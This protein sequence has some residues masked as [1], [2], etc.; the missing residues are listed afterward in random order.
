MAETAATDPLFTGGG[1]LAA[2][3][4]HNDWAAT[5]VGPPSTWSPGLRTAVDI[6]LSSRFSMWLG[7]GPELA[8]FY[9][10]AYQRDT[11]QAKHPWALGRPAR[12]VWA[13]IWEEIGPRIESVLH[14]GDAT[15]DE[16]LR[17]VL[18]RRGYPEE[19]YHTFSYSPLRDPAGEIAGMLCVVTENTERVLAGRR[20]AT[21]RDLGAAV[22]AE[23]SVHGVAG[24][25]ATAL[26]GNPHDV[27]FALLILEDDAGTPTL[28]EAVGVRAEHPVAD[29]SAWP[30][31]DS[32]TG[33]AALTDDLGDRFPN[34]PSGTDERPVRQAAVVAFGASPAT[35][36]GVLVVGLNPLRPWDDA[37]RVFVELAANQVAAALVAVHAYEAQARR[38]DELAAL[39]RAKTAFFANTSHEFRT[40]LT[41]M[42]G[43][44]DELCGAQAIAADPNLLR[45]VE[46]IRRNG[47]RL[48]KLVDNLLEFARI[49]A[50]RVEARFEP[51]DLAAVTAGLAGM[52]DSATERAGLDLVL[53][54]PPLPG[55][56]WVDPTMWEKVVLN[57]LSNAVK[58][59][60]AGTI[61]VTL[62]PDP[63]GFAHGI[64]LTVADTGVGV[65]E[66]EI[67]GLFAR[68]HQVRGAHG[69]SAEGSGIGL[70]LVKELVELHAGRVDATS[71]E[72]AGT[73]FR[74][75]LPTGSAHL[76]TDHVVD[77]DRQPA[78][79]QRAEQATPYVTEVLRWLPDPQA[80][81]ADPTPRETHVLVVDDNADMRSYVTRLLAED[82][83]VTAVGDG[84]AALAAARA[85]VPDL[86]VSDIMMPGLEGMALL[87]ALRGD[88]ATSAVPVLLLSARA[89]Q[90]AALGGLAG[91]ADDYLVKPFSA[92]EL[93]VRVAA[94]IELT[95][96]RRTTERWFTRLADALPVMIWID[97]PGTERVLANAAW[98]RFVGAQHRAGEGLGWPAELDREASWQHRIHPD[99]RDRYD[100]ARTAAQAHRAPFEV[101]YRLRRDDGRYRWVLDRGAPFTLVDGSPGFA[102]SC[103]DID[104]RQ[105]DQERQR[106]LA[107]V[108]SALDLATTLDRRRRLLVTTLVDEGMVDTARLIA[109]ERPG[110]VTSGHPVAAAATS[111]DM[112]HLL[113]LMDPWWFPDDPAI[114]EQ[115]RAGPFDDA[116]IVGGHADPRQQELRS[117]LRG[118]GV[119]HH[120]VVPL[121]TRGQ[122][123]GLLTG[124]RAGTAAA[125]GGADLELLIEIGERAATALDNVALLERELATSRRLAVLQSATGD[126]SAAATPTEVAAVAITQFA[127]LL[128]TDMVAAW[129]L[130]G[131]ALFAL[132]VSGFPDQLVCEAQSVPADQVPVVSDVVRTGQRVWV[133]G[134]ADWSARY[135]SVADQVGR[136]G[137]ATVGAVPLRVGHRVIGVVAVGHGE[138][139]LL[140]DGRASA[141]QALADQCGQALDRAGL[142]AAERLARRTAEEA[143]ALVAA[144]A[145]AE[146]PAQVADVIVD[147]AAAMGSVA[148]AV[149]MVDN[150][151][152]QVLA[153]SGRRLEGPRRMS[154]SAAHP[155]AE[156]VRTAGPLWPGH[157]ASP[158]QR[159]IVGGAPT[160]LPGQVAIPLTLA[161]TAVG[162]FSMDFDAPAALDPTDRAAL[163]VRATQY[164]QALERARLRE[165]E[166]EVATVL[167]RSLL[168]G[169]LPELDRVHSVARYRP[170][171]LNTQAGGDFYDVLELDGRRV[172]LVVGD[173]VGHGPRAA[174][175]MG[176]LSA[177]A[178][179]YLLDGRAPAAT[180]E[181]LDRFATRQP[182]ALG[183]TCVCLTLD[184]ATGEIV[185]AG[186]GHPPVVVVEPEVTSLLEEGSGV[187]LGVRGRPPYIQARR[188]IAP[189]SIIVAYTDGLVER[190]G[191]VIDTG[192]D[193][194]RTIVERLRGQ[195]VEEIADTVLDE[196]VGDDPPGDDIAFVVLRWLPGPARTSVSAQPGSL[197]ELRR[198]VARWSTGSGLPG[199]Q[200]AQLQL[201]I[202][203][204][205]TNIVEHAYR[206]RP[207]TQPPGEIELELEHLTSRAVRATVRDTGRWRAPD[208]G[209]PNGHG[210]AVLCRIAEDVT[211]VADERGTT[212]SFLLPAGP[213]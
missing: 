103:V 28:A 61:S 44:L 35:P 201:T 172:A 149:V 111:A 109:F 27:P 6:I 71:T 7:W 79:A 185:W 82:H 14:T 90:E 193:R 209:R 55:P 164:A 157:D 160:E 128:D 176:R 58:F 208:I 87:A 162:A 200:I 49:E 62:G 3:M 59:T 68:F 30:N 57:L 101:E 127:A 178:T 205:A 85:D 154:A 174:A 194:L 29:P 141:A 9:N 38:A 76:P 67:G 72:G 146:S 77:P 86:V 139:W 25:V 52:F 46:L 183:S 124:G 99:D 207:A 43:P 155:L 10:D 186:A 131:D 202:G 135:P 100:A 21:L 54:C 195:P 20:T 84:T 15:W 119:H 34:L 41:L 106:L 212:V 210:L 75:W 184:R 74:V 144:L 78:A 115:G 112:E 150:D 4:A 188:C 190:R 204:A 13:E 32:R 187:V 161:G 126:L 203:E 69:R 24:A 123:I 213:R 189:G 170:G 134:R 40:P 116:M 8:F 198:S 81:A 166:H 167:Q 98:T 1:L 199:H 31:L 65:P 18:E 163:L 89:G 19:T 56:V 177:A 140:D 181:R 94:R 96:L 11:L 113:E 179:G 130:R 63:A 136:A 196:L 173:V 121:R 48:G 171:A 17:L 66:S 80:G 147:A 2:A 95:R 60:F 88:P 143:G 118:L 132:A 97:G 42:L 83:R 73:T 165:T 159:P 211:V 158:T 117:Q 5:P 104:D 33:R 51:V 64:V 175:I 151:G 129:E 107:A 120:A 137:L 70:A 142:L 105:R 156:V 45:E 16:N 37:Y 148:T 169:T 138:E 23:R 180:L 191:E 153:T 39:D 91:G 122:T 114:P 168:P 92:V 197:A 206:D 108:G 145:R 53:T 192:M 110:D 50:G 133:S 125:F 26:A 102:G 182:E 47:Q 12:E 36:R 93:R 22:P 152:L